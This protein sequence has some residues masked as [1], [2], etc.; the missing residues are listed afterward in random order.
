MND[1]SFHEETVDGIRWSCYDLTYRSE[2]VVSGVKT[3]DYC[4]EHFSRK[5]QYKKNLSSET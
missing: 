5:A 3:L 1:C 2:L 4:C